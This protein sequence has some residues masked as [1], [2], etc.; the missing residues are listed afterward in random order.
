M[1]DAFYCF[2]NFSEDFEVLTKKDN[3]K[4]KPVNIVRGQ[5]PFGLVCV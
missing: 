1:C 2:K 4:I 5:V 3:S